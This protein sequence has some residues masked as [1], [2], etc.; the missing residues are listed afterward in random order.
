MF[1]LDC[2]DAAKPLGGAGGSS[3]LEKVSKTNLESGRKTK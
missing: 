1:L 2:A 3:K